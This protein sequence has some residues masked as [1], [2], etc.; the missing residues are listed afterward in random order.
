MKGVLTENRGQS[1]ARGQNQAWGHGSNST[2]P[3]SWQESGECGG[4]PLSH[5]PLQLGASSSFPKMLPKIEM[6]S[7][8]GRGSGR[9]RREGD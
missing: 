3:G 4:F 2:D 7:Q 5:T 1:E 8:E 9:R 6:G